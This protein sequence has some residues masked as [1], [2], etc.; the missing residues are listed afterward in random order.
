MRKTTCSPR[1]IDR[2]GVCAVDRH[3][4]CNAT[5]RGCPRYGVKCPVAGGGNCAVVGAGQGDIDA[6]STGER[7]SFRAVRRVCNGYC[8]CVDRF[9]LVAGKRS[10]KCKAVLCAIDRQ[11]SRL[12]G[13]GIDGVAA[14][15]G[16]K[17]HLCCYSRRIICL[18]LRANRPRYLYSVARPDCRLNSAG[19]CHIFLPFRKGAELPIIHL[20]YFL[21]RQI[22]VFSWHKGEIPQPKTMRVFSICNVELPIGEIRHFCAILQKGYAV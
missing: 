15:R 14:S 8:F 7:T 10:R 4:R 17:L 1:N 13:R 18:R 11:R 5:N 9:R 21:K 20:G 6:R 16:N 19:R 12:G 22:P 3:R 2:H